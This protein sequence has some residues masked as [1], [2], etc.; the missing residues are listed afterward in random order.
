[1]PRITTTALLGAFLILGSLPA[2]GQDLSD[3][4]AAA[5]SG[6]SFR[7][8][9]GR[10]VEEG[11]HLDGRLDEE[12]WSRATPITDFRQQEPR[13]GGQPTERT[14]IS[15]LIDADNLYI[16]AMLYDSNP[17]GILAFQRR[18]DEGLGTDD[19]FMWILDTFLDGRTG[20]FFEINPAGLMGDGII[21]G[22][23][24][25]G[26]GG[27]GFGG[28]GVNKS[29]DGIWE[30]R[31][32]RSAEGWSAEIRIPFRTLNFDPTLDTWGINFQR[33]IRR[34]NEEILWSGY[35]RNQGLRRPI[36]AGRLTG[37]GGMSQG[38]GL[39]VKPY[40][41]TGFRTVT[42]SVDPTTYPRDMGLD[43]SYSITPSLRAAVTVNTDF[44]EVEA[45]QRRVNLT[46]FPLRFPER[47]DFFLEGSGV[48]SFANSSGVSPYFSR[49]IG[50]S[51]GEPVPI[52]YGA[53]LGGQIGPTEVGLLQ[54]STGSQ[55][56]LPGEEFTVARV[57]QPIFEQSTI[58]AIYTR[59]STGADSTGF[60]PDVRHTA[61][62]DLDLFT[63]RLFGDKN[64]QFE[65][66]A[67]WNS[68]PDAGLPGAPTKALADLSARGLR[69]DF[70]NDTWSGHLS[71]RE[72]GSAYDPA[73]GFVTRNG[74]R[75]IEPSLNFGPRPQ[76]ID[77]L[78]RMQFGVTFRSM[79]DLEGPLLERTWDFNLLELQFE[80]GDNFE[81]SYQRQFEYLDED[82]E[83]SDGIDILQGDYNTAEFQ[84]QLRT[85]GRR[86]VSGRVEWTR[87]DFWNGDRA[88]YQVNMTV[89]PNPGISVG[90][91][92]ELN[93]V[94]LP[95]GSFRTNLTNL[96][97]A[98]DIS[99]WASLTGNVQYD[100]VSEL[101][102]L[103]TKFRWILKPGNDLFLVYTHNWM[104]FRALDAL[105]PRAP[106]FQTL[107]RGGTV[108]ANY[109][110]RF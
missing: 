52:Q 58:G 94:T 92:Y 55:G 14:A 107:S 38:L 42:E 68:D 82:F 45:D 35:R 4:S 1:M 64:A 53:R 65:A 67:V 91:G 71:Y 86:K 3:D 17:D 81:I 23:G 28:G 46:R 63:S 69:F 98:W 105:D 66:F 22:G 41:T 15:V 96:E 106:G 80:S 18:R 8:E 104:D 100:D 102:G 83:V 6:A 2:A 70:P 56:V 73:V 11:L 49:N 60:T 34:K 9:A 61:G 12:A 37:L 13:E 76:N 101:V 74:F 26:F 93:D 31:V 43:V 103:F 20:Y 21:T 110:Y 51:G 72:F 47:R 108:K 95:Q 59:R 5:T 54:V 33:T 109:T 50:L 24:G 84:A 29:W 39:E 88:S 48:Y 57:R 79:W 90:G 19:R 89:R 75:R 78:R 44:A 30:A 62:V 32:H 16:G 27:G 7:L 85:A 87:G 77:W 99:P 25:G 40:A 97:G 36:H 10:L